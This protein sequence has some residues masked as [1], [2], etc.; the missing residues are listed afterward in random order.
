MISQ[1]L[2]RYSTYTS[3]TNV[4]LIIESVIFAFQLM[5]FAVHLMSGP[6]KALHSIIAPKCLTD[7][8]SV[9][10]VSANLLRLVLST[11]IFFPRIFGIILI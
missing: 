1:T 10:T 7:Q 11:N 3:V 4:C 2:H 6:Y 9:S 8:L 5:I